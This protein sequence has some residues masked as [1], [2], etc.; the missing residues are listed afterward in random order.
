MADRLRIAEPALSLDE[1][2]RII[3]ERLNGLD[4]QV[5]LFGSRARGDARRTSDIDIGLWP[6]AP[7]PAGLISELREALD[8]SSI[9]Y[10]VD[11]VDLTAV[12]PGLR[13]RVLEEGVLWNDCASA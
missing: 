11:V 13:E 4:V 8:E 1:A 3:F 6:R 10:Y 2:R 9:P 7:L 5:F 12:E